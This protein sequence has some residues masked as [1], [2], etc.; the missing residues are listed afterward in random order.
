MQWELPRQ[1]TGRLLVERGRP[2]GGK[3][4]PAE[5]SG[6][7]L[8]GNGVSAGFFSSFLTE[9]QQWAIV[10]G[11]R[12]YLSVGDF[13]LPLVGSTLSFDVVNSS[14]RVSKTDFR[15]EAGRHSYLV[16]EHSHGDPESQEA[17]LF[18]NFADTVLSGRLNSA[19]PEIALKTQQV[20]CACVESARNGGQPVT[21]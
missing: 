12:G 10:S 16:Q 9:I 1:V 3:P 7:L 21:M 17:N 4:V 15:M 20:M 8:Y 6:E 14:Y 2:T 19:W 11:T 13:V 18:R 5:F